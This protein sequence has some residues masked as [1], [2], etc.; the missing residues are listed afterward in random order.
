[1][2]KAPW[3]P[4]KKHGAHGAF[5]LSAVIAVAGKQNDGNDDQPKGAVVKEIA[6]TVIHNCSSQIITEEQ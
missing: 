5:S 1:M 6:K 2:K 3:A 4:C